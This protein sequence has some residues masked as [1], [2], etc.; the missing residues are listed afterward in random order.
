MAEYNVCPGFLRQGCA[1]YLPAYVSETFLFYLQ[2]KHKPRHTSLT[3]KSKVRGKKQV[4]HI[5]ESV[6]SRF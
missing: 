2:N 6:V 1:Q 3:N 4:N 5:V